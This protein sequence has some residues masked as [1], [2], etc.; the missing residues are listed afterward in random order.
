M[1]NDRIEKRIELKAPPSRVWQALTDHK[2]FNA[3]FGV[4][5]ES[6]FILGEITR[7]R[8]T[9]PGYGHLV[10]RVT[11]ER[12]EPQRLFSYRWHPGVIDPDADYSKE[13]ST[14][15]EFKLEPSG[16][17]T[18]LQLVESGFDALPEAQREQVY[19]RNDGGWTGQMKNIESH[20]TRNQ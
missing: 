12:M 9:T 2:Q 10:M 15:V 14:L 6:P 18:L 11:V 8:I 19:W 1:S 5:L 4:N 17:G 7:G 13:P 3:W 16:D 20:V